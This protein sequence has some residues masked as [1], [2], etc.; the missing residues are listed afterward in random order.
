[1]GEDIW[2]QQDKPE[3][4]KD[5]AREL[6][7]LWKLNWKMLREIIYEDKT[8]DEYAFER[9]D[10]CEN[11]L[12]NNTINEDGYLQK[13]NSIKRAKDNHQNII[14]ACGCNPVGSI[15]YNS[16]I[17]IICLPCGFEFDEAI[18]FV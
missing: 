9:L 11:D 6:T 13:C 1:M 10:D 15:N 17:K 2:F 18:R 7:A 8:V 12:A 4:N 3:L 16:E 14:N 5:I